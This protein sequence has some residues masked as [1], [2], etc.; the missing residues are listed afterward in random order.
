MRRLCF[1][2][3][4]TILLAPSSANASSC[5]AVSIC[6]AYQSHPVVFRGRVLAASLM[7]PEP[8]SPNAERIPPDVPI[9]DPPDLYQVRFQILEVFKG[10]PGAEITLLTGAGDI[11]PGDEYLVFVNVEAK[12]QSRYAD[13]CSPTHKLPADPTNFDPD[14]ETLRAYL[15]AQGSGTLAGRLNFTAEPLAAADVTIALTGAANKTIHTQ[16]D[17]DHRALFYLFKDLAPGTYTIAA[18]PPPG[19]AATVVPRRSTDGSPKIATLT[20]AGNSCNEVNWSLRYDSHIRGRVTDANGQPVANADVALIDRLY[21][22]QIARGRFAASKREKTDANGDYDFAGLDPGSYVVA[23]HS[24]PPTVD[25]PLA[26]V[27]YPSKQFIWEASVLRIDASAS[28]DDINFV[29]P[30]RLQPATVHVHV[31]RSNGS[32]IEN[33]NI[34]ATDPGSAL[35]VVTV[36]TDASGYADLHLFASRQYSIV[37]ATPDPVNQPQESPQ[38]AGPTAFIAAD[39]LTLPPLTPDKTFSACRSASPLGLKP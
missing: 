27:F 36:R 26:P 8:P 18:N 9:L 29:Q 12:T 31:V 5:F 1:I 16:P 4:L 3:L 33:A 11:A 13:F 23:L 28:H 39:D 37:A 34:I 10:E 38:C 30:A 22:D 32:P 21:P 20:I 2:S 14:L 25:N 17:G 6:P 15:G 19:T 35:Q 7:P 24:N